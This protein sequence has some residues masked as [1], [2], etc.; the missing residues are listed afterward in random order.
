M[1]A[2][3]NTYFTKCACVTLGTKY[4]ITIIG[5]LTAYVVSPIMPENK[6]AESKSV[7]DRDVKEHL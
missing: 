1:S 3:L 4:V 2:F 6:V 7:Q 5:A